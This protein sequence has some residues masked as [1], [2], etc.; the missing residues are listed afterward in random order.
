[1]VVFE[2]LVK[3]LRKKELRALD[4]QKLVAEDVLERAQDRSDVEGLELAREVLEWASR[5]IGFLNKENALELWTFFVRAAKIAGPQGVARISVKNGNVVMKKIVGI[6][7]I[8]RLNIAEEAFVALRKDL[9]FRPDVRDQVALM[10]MLGCRGPMAEAVLVCFLESI[11]AIAAKKLFEIVLK[12]LIEV[13]AKVRTP[14]VQRRKN[15]LLKSRLN[16]L[17]ESSTSADEV[18]TKEDTLIDSILRKSFFND[19]LLMQYESVCTAWEAAGKRSENSLQS[20]VGSLF[21][22]LRKSTST[23]S[24]LPVLAHSYLKEMRKD[25]NDGPL[26]KKRKRNPGPSPEMKFCLEVLDISGG[27]KESAQVLRFM[28]EFDVFDISKPSDCELLTNWFNSHKVESLAAE[29]AIVGMLLEL[30]YRVVEPKLV[31]CIKLALDENQINDGVEIILRLMETYG[32]LRQ[33]PEFLQ[34]LGEAISAKPQ[35]FHV[36]HYHRGILLDGIREVFMSSPQGQEEEIWQHLLESFSQDKPDPVKRCAAMLFADFATS[37]SINEWNC[38][39]L[40]TVSSSSRATLS[41]KVLKDDGTAIVADALLG[42]ELLCDAFISAER[43]NERDRNPDDVGE[44]DDVVEDSSLKQFAEIFAFQIMLSSLCDSLS[45]A[46]SCRII[47]TGLHYNL[48]SDSV[49]KE[50][51]AFLLG[52]SVISQ[53]HNASVVLDH[54]EVFDRFAKIATLKMLATLIVQKREV[55]VFRRATFFELRRVRDALFAAIL[56]QGYDESWIEVC[57]SFPKGYLEKGQC[58]KLLSVAYD[59]ISSFSAQT[60]ASLVQFCLDSHR[61]LFNNENMQNILL[62]MSSDELP[63]T[64][65]KQLAREYLEHRACLSF[66]TMCNSLLEMRKFVLLKDWLEQVVESKWAR[67]WRDYAKEFSLLDAFP[68]N[69]SKELSCIWAVYKVKVLRQALQTSEE[70]ELKALVEGTITSRDPSQ[71]SVAAVCAVVLIAEDLFGLKEASAPVIERIANFLIERELSH[72]FGV[73]LFQYRSGHVKMLLRLLGR[74]F[75]RDASKANVFLTI[76]DEWILNGASDLRASFENVLGPWI[77][78]PLSRHAIDQGSVSARD[79]RICCTIIERLIL[80]CPVMWDLR[81]L[82]KSKFVLLLISFLAREQALIAEC[83]SLLF[84]VQKAHGKQISRKCGSLLISTMKMLL[85][86]QIQQGQFDL[87]ALHYLMRTSEEMKPFKIVYKQHAIFWLADHVKRFS[88]L[89]KNVAEEARELLELLAFNFLDLCSKADMHSL[90]LVL[91]ETGRLEFGRLR[92][93]HRIRHKF[94]GR[95]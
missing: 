78:V 8:G 37:I 21:S 45:Q 31:N 23:Q 87:K 83:G 93:E 18:P 92:K 85:G 55:R 26:L 44:D 54:I 43:A 86:S 47:C 38:K 35:A 77:L 49:K 50:V 24:L 33:L 64:F 69:V 42:V 79:R 88:K 51:M 16:C 53:E 36:F 3:T 40:R 80:R 62:E 71:E 89:R 41:R 30:D 2:E 74:S 15:V 27:K 9:E 11:N 95:I 46:A 28:A 60:T 56:E 7:E 58:S 76:L 52:D 90:Y 84:A 68:K 91:D 61:D 39:S 6:V 19:E 14:E 4:A 94:R 57:A 66:V 10:K 5:G 59:R 29:K 75:S 20:F 1:M 25:R 12:D 72:S 67:L 70:E 82:R 48:F 17:K 13:F 32:Q 73:L 63:K 22:F 65:V 34:I 81:T